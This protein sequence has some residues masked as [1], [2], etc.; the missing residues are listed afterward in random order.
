MAPERCSSVMRSKQLSVG[1][2]QSSGKRTVGKALGDFDERQIGGRHDDQ[3]DEEQWR[4]CKETE[5]SAYRDNRKDDRDRDGS[6]RHGQQEPVRPAAGESSSRTDGKTTH[7]WVKIASSL[8]RLPALDVHK[9][10]RP[11]WA[12]SPLR[13]IW[14]SEPG[15]RPRSTYF[16]LR[17]R[18]TLAS[19]ALAN[20]ARSVV[21]MHFSEGPRRNLRLRNCPTWRQDHIATL[22]SAGPVR[23]RRSSY[24]PERRQGGR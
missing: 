11:M 19:R 8:H 22:R 4:W 5:P 17:M 20:P 23:P 24:P 21:D 16:S 7:T 13:R 10:V 15:K 2:S 6:K 12:S 18:S 14:I 9:P 1:K 3:V